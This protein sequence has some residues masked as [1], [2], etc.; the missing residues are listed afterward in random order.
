MCTAGEEAVW[1][2]EDRRVREGDDEGTGMIFMHV[3]SKRAVV[4]VV[5]VC[6][7]ALVL[8]LPAGA[9]AATAWWQLDSLTAPGNLH[10]GFARSE[11]Q[12]LT[13]SPS[14]AFEL[15]VER[16]SLGF[17]E[18][19]PYPFEALPHAT[20]ANVQAALEA[21]GG[22]GPGNVLVTGQGPEG[23]PPLTVTSVNKDA[24]V[25]VPKIRIGEA[26]GGAATARVLSE[27]RPD[28]QL[29]VSAW[30]MGD[31]EADGSSAP[32]V[33]RDTLP[34]GLVAKAVS[35][36]VGG[37]GN[38]RGPGGFTEP[39]AVKCSVV[40]GSLVECVYEGK[41]PPYEPIEAEIEVEVLPGAATGET[42]E[43]SVSGGGARSGGSLKRPI[44]VSGTPTPYG[45]ANYE[46]TAFNEDGSLA[47]QAGSHP[48]ALTTTLDL[49]RTAEPPYQPALPKDLHF[50]LPPGLVGNPSPFPRC[51]DS[52]FAE[53]PPENGPGCP[54]NT[55]LGVASI[56]IYERLIGG[57][58][59][60][61]VP[62]F[63][64][65]PTRGEPARFGFQIINARV[66]LDTSVR[67]GGDYGVTVSVN[68]ITQLAAFLSSR[69]TFWGVPGDP[70]HDQ[71]RGWDCITPRGTGEC[72]AQGQSGPPPFL[73]LPT[74]CTDPLQTAVQADSWAQAGVFTAP[75]EAVFEP[76][77]DG[78]NRLPFGP[79]ISVAPD[80]RSA[81][82]PSGLTVGVHVPQDLILASTTLA[83][84]TVKDTTVALPAGV[85]LN[86][87]AADGLLACPL[88][89]G[90][91]K[92][93][94][95]REGRREE[96]G[97]NLESGQSANCPEA[98][99]VGTVEIKT[100]LLPNALTGAVYVAAQD[101]NPFG[102]LL[103]LYIVAE[104]PI[105][106]TV[107]KLAGKVVPDP[108]TGQLV[109]TFENTPQLPFE[110]LKLQFFG[111]SRAP[112]GT[113]AFCG[114]YTT[115]ASIAPW[116]GS[117][118]VSPSSEFQILSG[119]NGTS[120]SN[121]LPFAPSLTAGSPNINAG[122]FTPL[123]TTITREDGNQDIQTVALHFPPG[124]SGILAGVKLCPEAQAN[125][126]TCGSE[127]LLGHTVV[128]V[129]LGNDP[130]SV[131]GGHVYLTE[132]YKGAPFGLSIV[133]PA[134]AGPF[135]L[136][137]VIV[138][139]K[140]DV[141]PHTAALTVTTDGSGPY[142]IP[143]I[144]DGIPL[145]IKHI[146]VQV[147]RPGFTFNPTN[148]NPM[149]ITGTIG[150]VGGASSPVSIPFQVTNCASLAF[151]PEFKASVTGATSKANGAGLSVKLAYPP[152]S[153]G[154]EANIGHV[155]VELPV[156]LPSRL[157]T[158]QQACI[159]ARFDANPAS[160]PVASIVG[161][162]K[163]V[164]PLLPVPLEGPA[165]F[166]SH[167]GERFPDLTI[168]LQGYGVT[169]QL[170]GT[171]FI[172]RTG[173]TST[174]F[175][176]PPDV[177]FNTFELTLPQG[178]YSALAANT[179]LCAATKLVTVKKRVA[180]RKHGRNT[181]PLRSFKQ[182][183]VQSLIMPVAFTAQNGAQLEQNTKLA[184]TGC[185]RHKK[186]KKAKKAR[187]VKRPTKKRH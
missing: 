80:A 83:E 178:K 142:A 49:S 143:R 117:A 74:S 4:S 85:A 84:S 94:E 8:V 51:P 100:P 138:R 13:V 120:C 131:T 67:T 150:S 180:V 164:T 114:P 126:G 118:A 181:H 92:G 179:N 73:S 32:V 90:R 46:L 156:Q 144:L 88:L 121:P 42:N 184:V 33:L 146:N 55:A 116:S 44:V 122:A 34:A 61:T 43:V 69:V 9:R 145:Q 87:A 140:I 161:H 139:A 29:R 169:V 60:V 104:D 23:T 70:T 109:S 172:S 17:F 25:R 103:A 72:K 59:T 112:L 20:A 187:D 93:K 89:K 119:P 155:K 137:N 105:S 135:D 157:T 163:V 52:V 81:S 129:G 123:D 101:A 128:S 148:C 110:D 18:S 47:T 86:P 132:G 125:A 66:L 154:R 39:E 62:V 152:G 5:A 111:G 134:K 56:T 165:Y 186:T 95:E 14:T 57:L 97:I 3:V 183:V 30:N 36:H 168:V 108:V 11:I 12:E 158:L 10:S 37:T 171:T 58:E 26:F 82:S 175:K 28:G 50:N 68:N 1:R 15:K 54:A 167:G 71:S 63:N 115:Q 79:S 45:P 48:Y 173:I 77:L 64:L 170:V 76:S 102:S 124:M 99:K 149:S 78:C 127:S 185:T 38:P 19:E 7:L 174:T 40:S 6:A 107:V 162:A 96:T 35:G 159:A 147:D 106:G 2:R 31:T 133:N 141:D 177:P 16:N 160:C 130:F 21:E 91:D 41:L 166:V 22:Y 24:G 136:G 182:R 98:S 53:N 65:E 27:G 176:S 75:L 153:F 113:P 151:K